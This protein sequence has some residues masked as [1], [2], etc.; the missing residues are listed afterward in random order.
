MTNPWVELESLFP[1]PT[2]QIGTIT[3]VSVSTETSTITLLDG[4]ALTAS[5]SSWTI[6]KKVFIDRGIITGEAPT[7]PYFEVVLF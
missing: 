1:K 4:T 6:G 2:L 7:L 5:G 3:N